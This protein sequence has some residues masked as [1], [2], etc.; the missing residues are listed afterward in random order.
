MGKEYGGTFPTPQL[1]QEL[2]FPSLFKPSSPLQQ[3]RASLSLI[4]GKGLYLTDGK[5][6]QSKAAVVWGHMK[7]LFKFRS[8]QVPSPQPQG[9]PTSQVH[10]GGPKRGIWVPGEQVL[11]AHALASE[12]SSPTLIL[13]ARPFTRLEGIRPLSNVDSSTIARG[14]KDKRRDWIRCFKKKKKNISLDMH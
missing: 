11:L 3:T 6:K 14:E 7:S 12:H 1:P 10:C 5:R 9:T 4:G 8:H 2:V 13:A